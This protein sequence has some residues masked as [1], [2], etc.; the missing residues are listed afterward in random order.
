MATALQL[1]SDP[2]FQQLSADDQRGVLSHFDPAF[3]QLSQSDF[4]GVVTQLQKQALGRPDLAVPPQVN[5]PAVDMQESAAGKL[6]SGPDST[7]NLS[8][9]KLAGATGEADNAAKDTIPNNIA[10]GA[11]ASGLQTVHTALRAANGVT[12][13][14]IPGLP[15]SFQ[16]PAQLQTHGLAQGIGSGLEGIAEFVMGDEALKGLSLGEKVLKA[17]KLAET[18]EKATP[19]VK[20]TIDA[21]MN[22]GRTT[23]VSS[24]QSALHPQD[25]QSIGGAALSGAEAGAIGGGIGELAGYGASKLF[26]RTASVAT[27]GVPAMPGVS[28]AEAGKASIDEAKNLIEQEKGALEVQRLASNT[29]IDNG[30]TG[31]QPTRGMSFKDAAGLI[32]DEADPI[33]DKLREETGGVFNGSTGRYSTNDFDDAADQIKRAKKVIFS[34]TPASTDALKTAQQEEVEGQTKLMELFESA[35]TV[36]PE[37]LDYA[38]E[39]WQRANTLENLHGFL[40]KALAEPSSVNKLSGAVPQLDPKRFVTQANKAIDTIGAPELQ[41]AMGP[42]TFSDLMELRTGMA[43]AYETKQSQIRIFQAARQLA[44]NSKTAQTI[45]TGVGGFGAGT[46]AHLLGASNPVTAGIG[47]ITALAHWMYT[48]PDQ[49]VKILRIVQKAAP[50]GLQVGKQVVTHTYNSDTQTAEPVPQQ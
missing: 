23:A 39:A 26:P 28:R 27:K 20:G 40:D 3:G 29:A 35:K 5:R 16:E 42:S 4:A 48:H 33:Y 15:T 50:I 1:V 21:A 47:S 46:L 19:L 9:P 2:D 30:A 38:R 11:L 24:A 6:I 49:G 13:D 36:T 7:S 18:Y 12:G 43:H 44:R 17:A 8:S 22:I 45:A 34:P 14:N 31:A 10:T 32:R 25:G 41:H 37:D